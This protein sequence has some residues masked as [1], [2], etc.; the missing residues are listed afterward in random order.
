MPLSLSIPLV[1]IG[2]SALTGQI[3][4]VREMLVV[5]YGNELSTAVI[6]ASWLVWSAFG[7]FCSGAVTDSLKRKVALFASIQGVL[8]L[9]LPTSIVIVRLS[10]RLWNVPIGETVAFDQ[11]LTISF[12]VLGPFCF[13]SGFLF[14][15]GCSLY[16]DASGL[17]ENTAGNVYWL[18]ALGAG[19]GGIIFA[20]F[21]VNYLNHIQTAI[22]V[23][24]LLLCSVILSVSP[25]A[26][27]KGLTGKGAAAGVS[28]AAAVL[29]LAFTAGPAL[30]KTSRELQ[31]HGSRL[32]AVTDTHY[33]NLAAVI[34][35]GEISFYE[36]GL[37]MFTHPD[38]LSAEESVHF[39]LLTHPEPQ[40][41]LLIGGGLSSSLAET[42]KHPS[43]RRTDYVETDPKSIEFGRK[44]LPEKAV[45]VLEDP[46]VRL[47]QT[48]GRRHL[49][50]VK[51]LYD[52]IIVD[53]PDPKTAQL[54]RFYTVEFFRESRRV[55]KPGGL[56]AVSLSSSES[57]I[58]P[59]L[60]RSLAS[61]HRT[62]KAAYPH[63]SAL[64]GATARFFASMDA[65]AVQ[66]NPRVLSERIAERNINLAHVQ[67]YYILFNLSDGRIK[68]LNNII[69]Q[70][71]KIKL[72]YDLTPSCYFYDLV[73]WSSFH[74][75]RIAS[76]LR[77]FEALH[78]KW[79]VLVPAL[80]CGV[81][82]TV[83]KRFKS[84][85]KKKPPLI[86]S[87]FVI[88]Y[89][90][91]I[92]SVLLILV[93]QTY[94]GSLYYR[95]A[96]L[97]TLHM[98]GVAVG[99]RFMIHWMTGIRNRWRAML[100]VQTAMAAY[101]LLLLAA[102]LFLYG[103]NPGIRLSPAM[104]AGFGIWAFLAGLI[105]GFHFPLAGNLLAEQGKAGKTGGIVYGLDL[106][107]SALGAISAGLV[108][109]PVFG[110]PKTL[111]L[112]FC[113]NFLAAL[114]LVARPESRRGSEHG[115]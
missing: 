49:N 76:M 44:V 50:A 87:C 64:P 113:W 43:I 10:K 25:D 46:R 60:A 23:S 95:V 4:L 3:V 72:N 105:G 7:S 13:L 115:I 40:D 27:G 74:A 14:A 85:S 34:T 47:I 18:D 81:L 61:L 86:M 77:F 110:I 63:V 94:Y 70:A 80:I 59:A 79:L 106:G 99:S 22:V 12:T 104:E 109:L 21:L 51:G 52:V 84:A 102:I 66:A 93:F 89:S 41:V 24:A 83:G 71:H 36:N 112:L 100:L 6:L 56:I 37:W 57:I 32:L 1:L 78:F 58:G 82:V 45:S 103:A 15:L 42:L 75:P 90:E 88:G 19:L 97:I 55:L 62:M 17:R 67:D 92:L 5:F 20:G 96:F 31:W 38:S 30:E 26:T 28:A 68:Y 73:Q 53:L 111:V 108:L 65:D 35:E 16:A 48:D 69:Q 101:A 107:G 8:S 29:F 9:L 39:A 98:L 91:M 11:M 33:G 114:M 2:L 54:N